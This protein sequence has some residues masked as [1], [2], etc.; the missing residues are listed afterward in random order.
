MNEFNYHAN[1]LLSNTNTRTRKGR[2]ERRW[3]DTLISLP[4]T[5]RKFQV[6]T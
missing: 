2:Q 6:G 1:D 3:N 4:L 5:F